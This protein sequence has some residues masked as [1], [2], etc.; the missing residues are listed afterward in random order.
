MSKKFS[1]LANICCQLCCFVGVVSRAPF[2]IRLAAHPPSIEHVQQP[3]LNHIKKQAY[4]QKN[5]QRPSNI[6]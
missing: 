5:L 6:W 1:K 4:S 2:S 3:W